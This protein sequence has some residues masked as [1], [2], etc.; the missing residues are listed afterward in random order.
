[1]FLDQCVGECSQCSDC[2]SN[3]YYS[4]AEP[5]ANYTSLN[6]SQFTSLTDDLQTACTYGG[7]SSDA[8]TL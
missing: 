1:M 4:V 2:I 7:Y 3:F 5:W 8:C 6:S